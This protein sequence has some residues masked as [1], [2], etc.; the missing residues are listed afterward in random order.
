[1]K[2]LLSAVRGNDLD[3][4]MLF[5]FVPEILTAMVNRKE[6]F[7]CAREAQRGIVRDHDDGPVDTFQE[8]PQPEHTA[9]S[10]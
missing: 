1:M 6:A 2:D 5:R 4:K 8:I 3:L 7:E 10:E 9:G